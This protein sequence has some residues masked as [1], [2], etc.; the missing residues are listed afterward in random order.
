[1][2][3][4]GHEG[5]QARI[6]VKLHGGSWEEPIDVEAIAQPR[7]ELELETQI[8]RLLRWKIEATEVITRWD[9]IANDVPIRLGRSPLRCRCRR[10]RTATGRG[11]AAAGRA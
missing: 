11:G 2:L 9:A 1:M 8:D 5:V 3:D 10:A 7:R 4:F 6:P